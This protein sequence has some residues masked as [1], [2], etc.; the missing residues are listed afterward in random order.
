M[1]CIPGGET[2][3]HARDKVNF[4]VAISGTARNTS[5]LVPWIGHLDS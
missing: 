5:A 1:H 3:A 4:A 2:A